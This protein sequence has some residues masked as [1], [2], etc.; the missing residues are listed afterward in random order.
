MDF[1]TLKYKKR[2]EAQYHRADIRYP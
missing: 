2:I 1:L